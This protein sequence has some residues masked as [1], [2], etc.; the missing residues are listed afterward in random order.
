MIVSNNQL[1]LL[2]EAYDSPKVSRMLLV[3][4]VDSNGNKID[5]LINEKT[6][7]L[8][9]SLSQVTHS[10]SRRIARKLIQ[11]IRDHEVVKIRFLG[12]KSKSC[13]PRELEIYAMGPSSFSDK[14][15]V[16]AWQRGGPSGDSERTGWKTYRISRIASVD[17]TGET[18][19]TP[20]H[21]RD[22]RAAR[23]K[24]GIDRMMKDVEVYT[25]F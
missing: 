21:V 5:L 19:S 10:Y 9:P 13:G 25:K 2:V 12:D 23:Y 24:P 4:A 16:R 11:A 15:L 22:G 20:I 7:K 17:P 8:P 6:I 18:F 1:S 14:F 3:E